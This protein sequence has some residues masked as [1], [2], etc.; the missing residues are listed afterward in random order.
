MVKKAFLFPGQGS[1][2]VGMGKDLYD[3][4]KEARLVFEEVDDALGMH[5]SKIIFE[6]PELELGMT[7]NTQP[8]IMAVSV[9]SVIA[10]EA[11]QSL[12][13][14][15]MSSEVAS[16]SLA[17]TPEISTACSDGI[18][19]A[20]HSLGEYSALVASGV[21]SISDAA[22]LLK[23]RGKAMQE[24]CNFLDSAMAALLGVE[25]DEVR[26]LIRKIVDPKYICEIANHNARE[27][28]VISGHAAGVE[29]MVEHFKSIG[30]KAVKLKVSAPFHSSLIVAAEERMKEALEGIT[31]VGKSEIDDWLARTRG[32]PTAIKL[33]EPSLRGAL[34]D[35]AISEPRS[36]IFLCSSKNAEIAASVGLQP[37]H[38]RNDVRIISNVT[39]DFYKNTEEMKELLAKQVTSTVRW[40]EIMQLL[41]QSGVYEVQEFGPG[42]VLKNLFKRHLQ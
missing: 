2:F 39:A 35:K 37:N 22:R 9:A 11:R 15:V 36:D 21:L 6:G 1:Q 14:G 20:G 16:H 8:A 10:S 40:Y 24:S 26:E 27:Q 38:S 19:F 33:R 31:F 30:K 32:Q 25:I 4:F 42:D 5:L 3:N 28:V 41:V 13:L 7:E 17:M 23:I 34:G 12:G 29:Q 18:I